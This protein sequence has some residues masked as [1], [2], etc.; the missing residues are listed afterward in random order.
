MATK[1]KRTSKARLRRS[2]RDFRQAARRKVAVVVVTPLGVWQ[3]QHA[4]LVAW[5]DRVQAAPT[6]QGEKWKA[7]QLAHIEKLIA[8]H[9]ANKPATQ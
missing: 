2:A 6:M 1:K 4:R 9:E 8:M 7:N 3:E 5:R